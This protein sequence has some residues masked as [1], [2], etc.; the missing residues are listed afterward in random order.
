M[1][2]ITESKEDSSI[3]GQSTVYDT[4]NLNL[5]YGEDQALKDINLRIAAEFEWYQETKNVRRQSIFGFYV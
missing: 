2:D 4:K 3:N 1:P 5:W